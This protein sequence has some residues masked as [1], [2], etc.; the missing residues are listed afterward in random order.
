MEGDPPNSRNENGEFTIFY[1]F[2]LCDQLVSQFYF[3]KNVWAKRKV[4][5]FC[6]FLIFRIQYQASW[7]GGR[8][9]GVGHFQ[10]ITVT[11]FL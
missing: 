1:P 10:A 4:R 7:I 6:P 5:S 3:I 8:V 11:T 9:C 2:G